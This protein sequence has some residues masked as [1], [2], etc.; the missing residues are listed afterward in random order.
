MSL[1]DKHRPIRT[2]ISCGEKREKKDLLR[3]VPDENRVV[4]PD[5]NGSMPGRGAYVC[6]REECMRR[7]MQDRLLG[8]AF[9]MR[10]PF[11][12]GFRTPLQ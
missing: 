2:C 6:G 10:G 1:G 3:L 5:Y 8:K 9:R 12:C 4:R 11:I 7:A